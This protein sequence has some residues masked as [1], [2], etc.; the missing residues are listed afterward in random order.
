MSMFGI[1]ES[2]VFYGSSVVTP[3][4]RVSVFL[5]LITLLAPVANAQ[6]VAEAEIIECTPSELS[7]GVNNAFVRSMTDGAEDAS[8]Q[9][10]VYMPAMC[11]QTV[12]RFYET[13]PIDVDS[14]EQPKHIPGSFILSLEQPLNIREELLSTDEVVRFSIVRTHANEP[15]FI[16]N[17]P[18]FSSQWHLQ[19]TGQGSGTPGEDANVTGAWDSVKGSGVLISVVDDGVDHQHSDLSPNYQDTIDWDYCG[20]DGNPTPTSNDGHGTSA[21]GV[22]AGIGDN[23]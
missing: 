8:A 4:M 1:M 14:F 9:W 2:K 17:D 6:S 13:L 16:P 5:I 11:G 15:R 18:S 7:F 22:A 3:I 20:N 21:G 23:N 19:N 12:D 10:L